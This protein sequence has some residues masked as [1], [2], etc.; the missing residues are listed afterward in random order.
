VTVQKLLRSLPTLC[1][2]ITLLPAALSAR[3]DVPPVPSY[4]DAVVEYESSRKPGKPSAE[5]LAVMQGNAAELAARL[6]DPGLKVGE[7]APDFTL[8]NAFGKPVSLSGQLAK[9]PVVLT[10]YRGA[11]CPYCNLELKSLRGTL[12]HLE[13]LGARLIAVTPQQPD[14]SLEQVKKDGYSFE[15]LS[16]LDG[17]VMRDYRLHFTVPETLS[18]LY[19]ER[20]GL[21]LATY[22]GPGRYELPVPGTFVIDRHGI[23]RAAFADTDYK[24]RMEPAEIIAALRT[25]ENQDADHTDEEPLVNKEGMTFVAVPAGEFVMG[26]RELESAAMERPDGELAQ[27]RD[28]TP[29]HRVRFPE[30]FWLGRTEVTQDQWLKVMGTRPGPEAHWQR[31]DWRA[32]P[33]VSVTWFDVQQFITALEKR[34]PGVTYRLPTEA[35]WEYA[36]R[37][38][39][40][41][42]RPMPVDKLPD[43]AWYIKNSGDDVQPVATRK[44]NI[45]GLHDMF[46]NVW[47]WTADWYAPDYYANAAVAAPSGPDDGNKKVRRGGSYHCPVHMVRPG[48]RSADDPTQSYSVVGFRLVTEP[49]H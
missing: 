27:V 33:V 49:N 15:I 48:Y 17:A 8:P 47:E 34:T 45:W 13:I 36:A 5:D 10:F 39:T 31:E 1:L 44:A 42:L 29:P 19:K 24:R 46:G 20:F 12:P 9:G 22:N 40:E 16:D 23:V 30:P 11:W 3:E 26:T 28:E 21:D 6:P 2:T 4:A 7:H 37:A 35:E 14:K 43:H 41:G 32:L 18:D 25:L 38:G